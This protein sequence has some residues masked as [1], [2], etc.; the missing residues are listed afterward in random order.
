MLIVGVVAMLAMAGLT[1]A[2]IRDWFD[3]TQSPTGRRTRCDGTTTNT[4]TN[5]DTNVSTPVSLPSQKSQVAFTASRCLPT[6]TTH[7]KRRVKRHLRPWLT[8]F[9]ITDRYEKAVNDANS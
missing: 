2:N 6:G 4:T 7:M 9:G 5:A 8:H 3:A 1:T